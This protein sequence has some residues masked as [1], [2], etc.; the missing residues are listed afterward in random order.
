[1][2]LCVLAGIAVLVTFGNQRA[3][4]NDSA[5][6]TGAVVGSA[7]LIAVA[8]FLL[9]KFRS[10]RA[11]LIAGI[12]VASIVIVGQAGQAAQRGETNRQIEDA[13]EELGLP[14]P[15]NPVDLT[16]EEE[17]CLDDTGFESDDLLTALTDTGAA[18]AQEQFDFFDAVAGC[19]PRILQTPENIEQFRISFS[20]GSPHM[21]SEDEASC[22]LAEIAE[23]PVPSALLRGEEIDTLLA[24]FD[25]CLTPESIAILRGEEGTGAQAIGDDPTLDRLAERCQ[26][27][28][29]EA[30]DLLFLNS[31]VGS[32][33]YD[34]AFECGGRGTGSVISCAPGFVDAN[35][36]GF[37]DADSRGYERIVAS[38]RDGD[39]LACDFAFLTVDPGAVEVERVGQTCGERRA[40][41]VGGTCVETYGE[42]VE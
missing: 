33:Y 5:R 8:F 26:D 9:R 40:L 31:S 3:E 39:M 38:C 1:M 20:S 13:I 24:L 6:I 23:E 10:Q 42:V 22:L 17:D 27:G 32:E 7:A 25:V 34:I 12:V 21:I 28:R 14:T 15:A 37:F 2:A 29:A 4:T 16:D 11:G 19:A 41:A 35:G 18:G 30:C 36:D